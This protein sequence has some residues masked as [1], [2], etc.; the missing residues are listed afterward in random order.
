VGGNDL[1]VTFN[2][3]DSS[4]Q[5]SGYTGVTFNLLDVN[6]QPNL[7]GGTANGEIRASVACTTTTSAAC[8]LSTNPSNVP[9][10]NTTMTASDTHSYAVNSAFVYGAATTFGGTYSYTSAGVGLYSGTAG[11]LKMD[12][13]DFVFGSAFANKW[14]VSVSVTQN[15]TF[16]SNVSAG[17]LSAITV[18]AGNLLP[19]PEPG[20]VVLLLAGLGGMVAVRRFRRA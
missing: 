13:Q 12:D 16:G 4:N 8:N 9:L 2:F 5:T 20:T 3:G 7:S 6:N 1:N 17:A 18:N 15:G 10:L 19:T 14:L 11:K